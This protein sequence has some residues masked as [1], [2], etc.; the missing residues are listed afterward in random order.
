MCSY[1]WKML[2]LMYDLD[3]MLR[4]MARR[5]YIF[6]LRRETRLGTGMKRQSWSR[7]ILMWWIE[8]LKVILGRSRGPK[9]VR[10][11]L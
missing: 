5:R 1:L 11:V 10:R 3:Q 6:Y 9:W 4:S 8:E 2:F 7:A